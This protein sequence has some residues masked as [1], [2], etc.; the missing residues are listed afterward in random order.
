MPE[1]LSD[2]GGGLGIVLPEEEDVEPL[3]PASE[4]P[5]AA[6][7]A[8]MVDRQIAFARERMARGEPDPQ[9]ERIRLE[10]EATAAESDTE[11]RQRYQLPERVKI[12]QP[13]FQSLRLS[14]AR[15]RVPVADGNARE[16]RVVGKVQRPGF[17]R[18]HDC[19][20]EFGR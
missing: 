11:A 1:V 10:A 14:G 5:T 19:I 4:D 15:H 9:A 20:G 13:A 7:R 16:A 8:D 6:A 12:D 2:E 17:G 3:A 18:V